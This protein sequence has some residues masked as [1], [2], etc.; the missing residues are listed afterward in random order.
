M[1]GVDPKAFKCDR[2]T[3]VKALSAEGV[4]AS[5]GYIL[6]PL[7]RNP[8]FLKHGFFAGKWPV[9]DLGLT[10]MDYSQH[11]T[12]TEAILQ[13]GIRIVIHEAMTEQYIEE[14]AAAV[15]KVAQSAW[16][17]SVPCVLRHLG[18]GDAAPCRRV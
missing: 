11:Q 10:T 5:A 1:F 15:R 16:R 6:V 14:I 18:Q 12:P 8:V 3:L 9:K 17:G 7:H 13:T 4:T 2:A